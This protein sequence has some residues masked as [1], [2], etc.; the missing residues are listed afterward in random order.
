MLHFTPDEVRG[1][2][3]AEIDAAI[4]GFREFNGQGR[5]AEPPTRDEVM[6]AFDEWDAREWHKRSTP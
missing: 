1:M 5:D 3:L 6:A 2:S 4:D